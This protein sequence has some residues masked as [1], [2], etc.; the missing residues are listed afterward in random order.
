MTEL[1]LHSEAQA[2]TETIH[3]TH[4]PQQMPRGERIQDARTSQEEES[5]G[6]NDAAR[7]KKQKKKKKKHG[8]VQQQQEMQND[9][10]IGNEGSNNDTEM[11]DVEVSPQ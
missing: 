1:V 9:A 7:K 5:G 8:A 6:K 3:P 11:Q 4:K 10:N 2:S